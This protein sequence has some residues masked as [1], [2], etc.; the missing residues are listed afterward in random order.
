MKLMS[1]A[2]IGLVA[3]A[4]VL[5]LLVVATAEK[6]DTPLDGQIEA[7]IR[8]GS[9]TGFQNPKAVVKL[10]LGE[11]FKQNGSISSVTLDGPGQ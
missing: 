9:G 4:G 11:D 5:N 8:G 6:S 10:N 1:F 7:V 2:G 3:L